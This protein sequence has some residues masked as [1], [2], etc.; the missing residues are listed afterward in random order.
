MPTFFPNGRSG[1]PS[2]LG[3]DV[4]RQ[5]MAMW[6]YLSDIDRQPLPEKL[7][8]SKV[9]NFELIPDERPILLRTF[10]Q[11]AGT[12]A[13]A[14]GF[15]AKVHLAFDAESVRVA[16]A[17]RGRFI[18][19]HGTWFDRFTPPAVPLGTDLVALPA[20]VPL[21]LL[22]DPQDSWPTASGDGS[23]YQFRG[24]RLDQD[25]IPTFL[26]RF[27][28]YEV[29]D[30]LA[31]TSDMQLARKLQIR[32][33]KV[34]EGKRVIWFRASVGKSVQQLSATACK[35]EQGLTTSVSGDASRP[36][37]L[38]SGSD[39][40]TEWIVPVDIE[41]TATIEVKYKW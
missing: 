32:D 33:T 39:D 10:M 14:V 27:D 2:I 38:R 34:S 28:R 5:I 6:T 40:L 9:H 3:G 36:G 20:G 37:V 19:A 30:R 41:Q 29:E 12:Q 17:W 13:I 7:T 8:A 26:Y 25:G 18:D 31:P 11:G 16:Q 35:N 1:V 21:A 23:G 15:P 4:E 24:Y 22:A